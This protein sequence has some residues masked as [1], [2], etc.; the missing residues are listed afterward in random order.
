MTFSFKSCACHHYFHE[1]N[2]QDDADAAVAISI[3][4]ESTKTLTSNDR[5]ADSRRLGLA[6]RELRLFSLSLDSYFPCTQKLRRA[7]TYSCGTARRC[8]C[9][10]EAAVERQAP[11]APGCARRHQ[12]ARDTYR[13]A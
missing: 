11:R 13:L 12:L 1:H 2:S 6:P 5:S 8:L 9:E 7:T 4:K 10:R 3:R